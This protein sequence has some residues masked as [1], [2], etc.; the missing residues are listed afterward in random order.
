VRSAIVDCVQA[1]CGAPLGEALGVQARHAAD[2]LA[3]KSCRAGRVGQEYDRMST[4]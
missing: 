4:A 2:F 1:S 3:L